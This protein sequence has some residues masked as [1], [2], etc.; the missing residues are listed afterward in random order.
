VI[1]RTT[2]NPPEY[3]GSQYFRQASYDWGTQCSQYAVGPGRHRRSVAPRDGWDLSTMRPSVM[4]AQRGCAWPWGTPGTGATVR[5]G[6]SRWRYSLA[7]PRGSHGKSA[8]NRVMAGT[9]N[10]LRWMVS[11]PE[12]SVDRY[13]ERAALTGRCGLEFAVHRRTYCRHLG[14]GPLSSQDDCQAAPRALHY[15]VKDY[16][17]QG[18]VPN[19]GG[20][21]VRWQRARRSPFAIRPRRRSFRARTWA[22]PSR[23]RSQR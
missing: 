17:E 6:W 14:Y 10:G 1:S 2:R 16:S 20:S 19:E 22:S 8:V 9:Q 5:R 21:V 23:G 11:G 4:P 7:A 12:A 13:E 18:A 3:R 15:S